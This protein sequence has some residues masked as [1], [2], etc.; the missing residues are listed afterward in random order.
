MHT[1]YRIQETEVNIYFILMLYFCGLL[2]C[3]IQGLQ[4]FF[5]AS[6]YLSRLDFQSLS[7]FLFFFFT[8]FFIVL[9]FV[10]NFSFL[11]KNFPIK[12]FWLAVFLFT[13]LLSIMAKLY[14]HEK[15]LHITLI[16]NL[17]SDNRFK[18]K[19]GSTALN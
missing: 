9:H 6:L 15:Y 19:K 14:K 1:R 2:L 12:I 13:S 3:I 11:R 5:V 8:S 16:N 18:E 4:S 10:K 7:L 17:V